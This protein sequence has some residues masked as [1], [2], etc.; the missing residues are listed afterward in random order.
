MGVAKR[1]LSTVFQC[2]DCTALAGPDLR[3]NWRRAEHA[4]PQPVRTRSTPSI[5]VGCRA[6]RMRPAP[7]RPTLHLFV[8][9][10][11]REANA[12]LGPGCGERGDAVYDALKHE[13]GARGAHASIWVTKTHCL[14]ICPKHGATV[15][16]YPETRIVTEVEPSD[17]PSF[18]P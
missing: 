16:V 4:R 6:T 12:P 1:I 18:L 13:V 10:N 9:A 15:A 14:G 2:N 3:D 11:R 7:I 17:A 8:C 5:R